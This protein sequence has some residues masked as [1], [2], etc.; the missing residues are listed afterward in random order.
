MVLLGVWQVARDCQPFKHYA[1]LW[2]IAPAE[3]F[4]WIQILEALEQ[5]N[6]PRWTKREFERWQKRRLTEILQESDTWAM[7]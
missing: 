4:R 1:S 3:A 2:G 7:N 5:A 6:W